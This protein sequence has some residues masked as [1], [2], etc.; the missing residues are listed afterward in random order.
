MKMF[1][2]F[3]ACCEVTLTMMSDDDGG[4]SALMAVPSRVSPVQDVC[5]ECG[6]DGVHTAS[7]DVS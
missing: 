6:A 7:C 1:N 4:D 3:C 5:T 2:N